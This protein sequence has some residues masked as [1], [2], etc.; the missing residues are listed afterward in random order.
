M[1]D[2]WTAETEELVAQVVDRHWRDSYEDLGSDQTPAQAVLTALADTGLLLAPGGETREEIQ[3]QVRHAIA[4]ELRQSA[5][6]MAPETARM[7][8]ELA[9]FI[10]GGGA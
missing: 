6:I 7:Y 5:T 1:T 9:D 8:R 3:V 10:D 4:V 2:R